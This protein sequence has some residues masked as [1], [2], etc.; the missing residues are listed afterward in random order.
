MFETLSKGFRNAK[1]RLSGTAEI[2]EADI[3]QALRDVRMSL[4]EADVDFKVTKRFLERVREQAVGEVVRLSARSRGR[5]LAIKALHR[6]GLYD[7]TRSLYFR[8]RGAAGLP[9]HRY[10]HRKDIKRRR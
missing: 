3:E 1:R 5:D 9:E 2:H 8:L 6:V 10:L 7:V 4:L